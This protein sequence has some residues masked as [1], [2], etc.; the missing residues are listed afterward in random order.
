MSLN[1]TRLDKLFPRL[2]YV[3]EDVLRPEYLS[4]LNKSCREVVAENS[5]RNDFLNVNSTHQ[6]FDHLETL[7][8]FSE[9]KD[10][11]LTYVK[12]FLKYMNYLPYVVEN[13]AIFNMW[14][15]ISGEGDFIFPHQHP[16]SLISGAFYVEAP[17]GSEI[18]FFD[19]FRN[20]YLP[21]ERNHLTYTSHNYTCDTNKLLLF[22]SDL[23]HGVG[24]QPIGDRIVISFNTYIKDNA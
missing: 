17:I 19:D 9:F 10:A 1:N 16:N 14:T 3:A 7:P 8:Q 15:N 23:I 5:H 22:R 13:I 24:S 6:T 2:V 20:F 21:Q 12:D 18:T 4:Q 11:A